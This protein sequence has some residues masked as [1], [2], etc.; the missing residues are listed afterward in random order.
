MFLP[1]TT[2]HW[3]EETGELGGASAYNAQ[4]QRAGR[5]YKWPRW[6]SRRQMSEKH[7]LSTWDSS[8]NK[9][10]NIVP[11][12]APDLCITSSTAKT[13]QQKTPR[14]VRFPTAGAIYQASRFNDTWIFVCRL[15]KLNDPFQSLRVHGKRKCLAHVLGVTHNLGKRYAQILGRNCQPLAGR[16]I[17]CRKQKPRQEPAVG[18]RLLDIIIVICSVE[19]KGSVY[20][21]LQVIYAHR[22]YHLGTKIVIP[23][24][25]FL[26]RSGLGSLFEVVSQPLVVRLLMMM[27]LQCNDCRRYSTCGTFHVDQCVMVA[28]CVPSCNYEMPRVIM[29]AL[30]VTCLKT[31]CIG[32]CS[33]PYVNLDGIPKT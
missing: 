6:A 12:W 11:L 3:R 31:C 23:V 7:W 28:V 20:L 1:R 17:L 21:L 27:I 18:V 14:D 26:R 33:L 30:T 4:I 8:N 16:N 32:L 2:H 9:T 19:A 22:H 15:E 13:Y 25:S 10:V 24:R 29:M 5:A